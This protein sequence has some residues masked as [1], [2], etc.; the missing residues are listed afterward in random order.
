[1]VGRRIGVV[2]ALI[3]SSILG[4]ASSPSVAFTA[5]LT[6]EPTGGACP[7]SLIVDTTGGGDDIDVGWMGQGHDS[8]GFGGRITLAVTGCAGTTQ[9]DCGMCTLAGLLAN[10]GD[11]A[12]DNQRCTGDTSILCGADGDCGGRGTCAFFFAPPWA[13]ALG[14]VASCLVSPIVGPV[15]GTADVAAGSAAMT[16]PVALQLYSGPTLTQPCPTC[17]GGLCA[18][19]A[20]DGLACTVNATSPAFGDTSFDCPPLAGRQIGNATVTIPLSTGMQTR[21]LSTANANCRAPGFTSLPVFGLPR[22][23]TSARTS[24]GS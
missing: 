24:L 1:M 6:V 22:S 11:V 9:P 13:V 8:Q 14:G 20:R 23:T 18:G 17:T 15:T 12:V 4:H 5:T 10:V 19:G 2:A 16:V 7:A 3:L 21:T